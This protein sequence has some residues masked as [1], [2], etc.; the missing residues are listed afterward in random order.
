MNATTMKGLVAAALAG[1]LMGLAACSKAE[2]PKAAAV[3]EDD[4]LGGSIGV[5]NYT[6][7]PIGVVYVNG[8]WAGGMVA[9]EGGTKW[10]GSISVPKQWDPNFKVTVKWSDD[11]LFKKDENALYTKEVPVEKYPPQDASFFY[12]AFYPNH[13]VKLY[14]TR[15][16]P[17]AASDPY[18]LENPKDACLKRRAEKD[19]DLCY[20]PDLRTSSASGVQA[21]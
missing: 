11:E 10:I 2:A 5:L 21:K 17:G 15:W 4:S 9:N 16:G 6:D 1:L 7:I 20:R 8:Q 18:H 13:E 14:L 12:V 3:E 19:S